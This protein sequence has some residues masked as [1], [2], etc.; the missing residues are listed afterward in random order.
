[1]QRL[2]NNS[3][4]LEIEPELVKEWHP[5][6][7]GDLTPPSVKI[8]YP[9]KVWWICSE[10]HEWQATIKCRLKRNDFQPLA[11]TIEKTE[12]LRLKPQQ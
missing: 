5:T 2:K 10:G 6:A 8:G 4:L 9:E 11:K 7:N 12:G 1:M 3:N